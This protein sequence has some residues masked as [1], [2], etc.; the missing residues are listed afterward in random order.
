M[1][2]RVV[3][4]GAGP[5]GI[6]AAR[7]LRQRDG[8]E[9][10]L[11]ERGGVVEY[12]PATI[13]V[14]LGKSPRGRWRQRISLEGVDVISGEVEELSENGVKV[15]GERLGADAVIASP[16]L[17]LGDVPPLANVHSFWDPAGAE[18][19]YG[20]LR[21][22]G[23]ERALVA[24]S[25]LPYRCPP[26]PYGMALALAR[27]YPELQVELST[28][29]ETPLAAIGGGVPEFLVGSLSE[30]GAGLHT[31]FKPSFEDSADG[32]LRSG[33]GEAID[34]DV[35]FVI[36][37][38][39]RSSILSDLEGEGPLVEVSPEFESSE[40][41]LFVVGDAAAAPLPRAADAAAAEGCIAADAVVQRLGVGGAEE[42]LPAPECYVYHGGSLFSR[43]S[44]RFPDGMPPLGGAEVSL[45]GP[46]EELEKGFEES[47]R[48]WRSLRGD[49]V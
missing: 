36:P 40:S 34:Y 18:R 15:G 4:V 8:V 42:H 16:G 12:L 32:T 9:V 31:G 21:D 5:G 17:A 19:A 22:F 24:I 26:A 10:T 29:D 48:R 37:P 2:A 7:R 1:T 30:A 14:F 47:F 46:S 44:M 45:E 20:A 38:H 43:I 23:G 39:V 28:P 49:G 11:I 33:S 35:A 27:E 3:I 13:P 6:A 25:S 41:G